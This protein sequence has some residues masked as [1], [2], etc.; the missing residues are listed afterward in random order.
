MAGVLRGEEGGNGRKLLFGIADNFKLDNLFDSDTLKDVSLGD[1]FTKTFED[2]LHIHNKIAERS[3]Y[4]PLK[5]TERQKAK[6]ALMSNLTKLSNMIDEF[7]KVDH[8]EYENEFKSFANLQNGIKNYEILR[9]GDKGL[10]T[11]RNK[12]DPKGN[13]DFFHVQIDEIEKKAQERLDIK[14]HLCNVQCGGKTGCGYRIWGGTEI[15]RCDL[16]LNSTQCE[17]VS[18]SIFCDGDHDYDKDTIETFY[19][20]EIGDTMYQIT[21]MHDYNLLSIMRVDED[22]VTKQIDISLNDTL[23]EKVKE[24]KLTELY[25][26]NTVMLEH[27][28]KILNFAFSPDSKYIV[29]NVFSTKN[30]YFKQK[31]NGFNMYGKTYEERKQHYRSDAEIEYWSKHGDRGTFLH[32]WDLNNGACVSRMS[33]NFDVVNKMIWKDQIY[34]GGRK[35]TLRWNPWLDIQNYEKENNNH[36]SL[37]TEQQENAV[38]GT[39]AGIAMANLADWAVTGVSQVFSDD[40]FGATLVSMS[41]ANSFIETNDIKWS[42]E[43]I[44]RL[45]KYIDDCV[46]YAYLETV[47]STFKSSIELIENRIRSERGITVRSMDKKQDKAL[48]DA[49]TEFMGTDKFKKGLARF[50]KKSGNAASKLKSMLDN[51]KGIGNNPS[52]KQIRQLDQFTDAM[53]AFA[54]TME[55]GQN[56]WAKTFKPLKGST[57]IFKKG[58]CIARSQLWTKAIRGKYVCG[59]SWSTC[60]KFLSHKF[61][62]KTAIVVFKPVTQLTDILK[63]G[64]R[65][66][67]GLKADLII[68]GL[69]LPVDGINALFGFG[70]KVYTKAGERIT[71]TRMWLEQAGKEVKVFDDIVNSKVFRIVTLPIKTV[72]KGLAKILYYVG[73]FVFTNFFRGLYLVGE[74]LG[75]VAAGTADFVGTVAKGCAGSRRLSTGSGLCSLPRQ[76]GDVVKNVRNAVE[77]AASTIATSARSTAAAAKVGKIA[78]IKKA[79]NTV[80]N[81]KKVQQVAKAIKKAKAILYL[82]TGG[83]GGLIYEGLMAWW[84]VTRAQTKFQCAAT[85]VYSKLCTLSYVSGEECDILF[86]NRNP[87]TSIKDFGDEFYMSDSTDTTLHKWEKAAYFSDVMEYKTTW[88]SRKVPHGNNVVKNIMWKAEK[89]LATNSPT[90]PTVTSPPAVSEPAAEPTNPP[91]NPPTVEPYINCIKFNFRECGEQGKGKGVCVWNNGC[92]RA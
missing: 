55:K 58:E 54:N 27:E 17:E 62:K 86:L 2:N 18:D 73:D 50:K 28:N 69:H 21:H 47:Y 59:T 12:R 44:E 52:W 30:A 90:A 35:S 1:T 82:A 71:S 53:G 13:D 34:L 66:I 4:I 25:K 9:S 14:K 49:V 24:Q 67:P 79:M 40:L 10:D 84:E 77:E 37:L 85:D 16:T 65:K 74:A 60:F 42:D 39:A 19:E 76:N 70:K 46:N 36:R 78:K 6:E 5:K 29:T 41:D 89:T 68:R 81:L 63:W 31:G 32:I 3:P 83:L 75:P 26:K 33:I 80:L 56:F 38:F 7:N 43:S 51:L 87:I 23:S 11:L 22:F 57:N 48:Q 20:V 8:I 92:V 61:G 45:S 91:T 64:I 72:L 88:Q 15:G